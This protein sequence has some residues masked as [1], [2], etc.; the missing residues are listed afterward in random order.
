MYLL[1]YTKPLQTITT[2]DPHFSNTCS[3]VSDS[4][5][6]LHTD[7]YT[8]LAAFPASSFD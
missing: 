4:L 1:M 5:G 8:F 3:Q 2:A 6:K 7:E